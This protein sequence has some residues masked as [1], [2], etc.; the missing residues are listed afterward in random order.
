MISSDFVVI[1]MDD[2]VNYFQ[3]KKQ[4]QYRRD[5]HAQISLNSNDEK[6]FVSVSLQ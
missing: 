2:H 3:T 1:E 5:R 6:S 4:L